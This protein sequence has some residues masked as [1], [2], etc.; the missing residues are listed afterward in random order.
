MRVLRNELTISGFCAIRLKSHVTVFEHGS[1]VE[2][3]RKWK[4]VDH[5]A[6]VPSDS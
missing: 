4:R 5:F 3:A 6:T 1:L 2:S